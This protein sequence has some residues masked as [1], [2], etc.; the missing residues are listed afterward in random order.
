MRIIIITMKIITIIAITKKQFASIMQMKSKL[1]ILK[2]FF[3]YILALK[4]SRT[5]NRNKV[6]K[7]KNRRH[8]NISRNLLCK[9]MVW[10]LY[11]RDLR[12]ERVKDDEKGLLFRLKSSF[13]S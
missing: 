7:E 6:E 8:G 1:K 5:R 4:S 2:T 9:S 12:H 13:R 10:F 3:K 11:D